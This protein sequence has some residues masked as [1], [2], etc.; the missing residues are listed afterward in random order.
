MG[1][2]LKHKDYLGSVEFS[3]EDGI[4]HGKIFGISDLV[5]YEGTSVKELESSFTEAVDDYL[6]TCKDINK[7]P[8]KLYRGLFNVRTSN[9]LHRNLVLIADKNKMKLNEVANIA[10]DFLIKNEDIVLNIE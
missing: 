7:E 2:Y 1:N 5:T 8:N 4:L 3:S 10:F 6:I 9:D